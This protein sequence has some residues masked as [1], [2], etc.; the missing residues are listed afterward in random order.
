MFLQAKVNSW[1]SIEWAGVILNVLRRGIV[2]AVSALAVALTMCLLVCAL[3]YATFYKTG[4]VINPFDGWLFALFNPP[5][6]YYTP[7]VRQELRVSSKYYS[8]SFTPKYRGKYDI[9]L[10]VV[11]PLEN[12]DMID[13]QSLRM[14][15]ADSGT[16]RI[17]PQQDGWRLHQ[18]WNS[19]YTGICYITLKVPDDIPRLE[20]ETITV[21]FLDGFDTLLQQYPTAYLAVIKA[22]DY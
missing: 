7:L 5:A 9:M 18:I 17:F 4:F 6:D 20:T 15:F 10:N 1:R 19:N 2:F 22:S 3:D 21:E 16:A 8:I 13:C 12:S 11:P 14:V